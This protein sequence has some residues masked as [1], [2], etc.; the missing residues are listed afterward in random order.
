MLKPYIINSLLLC[1][2]CS[3]INCTNTIKKEYDWKQKEGYRWAELSPGMNSQ[4]GFEKRSSPGTDISF[5][6]N[7]TKEDITDNRHYLNG[8]GVAA[9]DVDGDGW[10]DLYFAQLNGPNK[11][12]KNQGGFSRGD[13]FPKFKDI[14]DS[15]GVAHEGYYSTGVAFSDVDGDGDLDLFVAS[16]SRDNVLYLNDGKGH[17]TLQPNSGL[18]PARGTMTLA[19][20]DIEGDRDLDL[21]VSNY[22][23]KSV[24]DL[25]DINNL[26]WEKTVKEKYDKNVDQTYTLLPP[27]DEHYT[28]LHKKN[29]LPERREIGREDELYLNSGDGTFIK[30]TGL[31]QRFLDADG[32]PKG[33]EKDLGLTAKFHDIN[34]DGLPDLYINNDFWTKD[35]IWINQGKGRFK[36]IDPLAIRN[37][38]FSSMSVDFSD[39]NRDGFWD[40]FVTEMLSSEHE[41][42]LRQFI[43]DDPHPLYTGQFDY[44]PQYNRNSLYL[45]RGDGTYAEI[46]YF[47]NLEAS[48]WSWASRFLDVDLDGY[49]DLIIT[50]GY[51][52]DVQDLD[53]QKK[54]KTE[55]AQNNLKD[56]DIHIYPP[57]ELPNKFFRNDGGLRFTEVSSEWG[58]D[59]N[60]VS[61]GLATADFDHDG[62]LDLAI[63]RLNQ[64]AGIYENITAAPRIAIRLIGNSPNTQAIGAKVE[65]RGG[66]VPQQDEVSAGGEYLSGS[67]P[68]IVFA[69]DPDNRNHIITITWPGKLAGKQSRIDS[70]RAN[71]IYEIEE[72]ESAAGTPGSQMPQTEN[73]TIFEDVSDRIRHRHHEEP[74]DDFRIQ[75]LLPVKLS[76]QGPGISWIDFDSDRDDDL[77][78]AS[79]RGGKLAAFENRGNGEFSSLSLEQM[80]ENTPGDQTAILGW[81]GE[82]GT[83]LLA[84]MANYEPGDIKAPSVLSYSFQKGIITKQDGIPGMFST[85]GALAASDYD[86]DGD[87]DLFVG[88]R[89]VPAHYP[90]NA[91]S[92]L[93]INEDGSF[94]PDVKNS[95][96]LRD[97]GLVTGA[98]FT[99][100]DRDGDPDLLCSLEWGSIRLFKNENG[101]FTEISGSTGLAA[102]SGWW[103]GI[104]TGDFNNDGLPDIVVTNQGLNSPYQLESDH[105]LK[106][107]YQDFNRDGRIDI[108]ESYYDSAGGAYVPRRQMS[109][110][111]SGFL[112][113]MVAGY[114]NQ[115]FAGSSL[116]AILG[117]D[118]GSRIPSKEINTLAH[119]IFINEGDGFS[120]YPLPDEAQFSAAFY[121]GVADYDN[122]GNED[123]FLSQNFFQVRDNTPRLDAGRGLWLKGDGNGNFQA[124]PG[125]ISGIKVYGEQR[126]AALSDFNRDG[127][128]DLVVSQNGGATKLYLNRTEKPGLRVRLNGPAANKN[129]I[130]SAVRLIYTDGA[131]GPLREIQAGSGYWSQN[132]ATQVMGTNGAVDK[133]E[134]T[135][136]DGTVQVV[137]A[138]EDK[139]S[140]SIHYSQKESNN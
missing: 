22:K 115:R 133:I 86:G 1:S 2:I 61:H 26:S 37:L 140:Y 42:R 75:P 111:E 114:T 45:N 62:D 27:F 52:Y 49:E 19:L 48:E 132:S 122:D 18:D 23:R 32:N 35:R 46:S 81:T 138:S 100:Y 94:I 59:E 24:L 101:N 51:T 64:E 12:Y 9:G 10:T 50:T 79:G 14:T 112:G 4:T 123:L 83:K 3:L 67:D 137:E 47:S 30:A 87:P 21:Y 104:A 44:Q 71:R 95:G 36:A 89:F 84:G 93:F 105:P 28:I 117:Y 99:D 17:F 7:L 41:R 129:G 38:S 126:G 78:I 131:K 60:D 134:I 72:P 110:F 102:Y 107:Y 40:F 85:T 13:G 63:N 33:F 74:Y 125:H 127:K 90:M 55:I 96:K 29:A 103:N 109:K 66:P 11:L 70:V 82:Q 116:Q 73:K 88:G 119:M 53:A 92:R 5:R 120:A 136:F 108:I 68:L 65:L 128:V 91:T 39:I 54:W 77:F 135:W 31:D 76:K 15:A 34:Q 106:M 6:N 130:G 43:P 16:M 56:G 139:N 57:L 118:P 20:A 25:F 121:A 113:F 58:F 80:T 98:V 124:V 69:A 97:L 8:S